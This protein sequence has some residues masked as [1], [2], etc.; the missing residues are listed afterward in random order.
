MMARGA[1]HALV[2]AWLRHERGRSALTILG[3][4]LGVAVL[5]AIDL[6]IGSSVA[7]FKQTL[8]EVAGRATLTIRS[9][10]AGLPGELAGEVADHPGVI[11]TAPLIQTTATLPAQDG[12]TTQ[13]ML[14]L[15]VD[16]LFSGQ[17]A[18]PAVREFEFQLQPERALES[19]LIDP[20]VIMIPNQLAKRLGKAAGDSFRLNVGGFEHTMT[21]GAIIDAGELADAM[22]GAVGVMDIAMV[23]RLLEANGRIDRIDLVTDPEVSVDTVAE[24]LRRKLGSSYLVERPAARGEQVDAMMAA[25]R[26]NLRALG[27]ISILVGAFLIFNTMNVAVVRRTEVIGT[28]RAMGLQRGVIRRV[29]LLEGAAMGIIGS[30]LGIGLG[31]LMARSLLGIVSRA[32]SI[33]Y[34]QVYRESLVL[35]ETTLIVAMVL[36]VGGAVGAAWGPANLAASIPPANTMR[37][38]GVQPR[39]GGNPW[40]TLAVA[41]GLILGAAGLIRFY[42]TSFSALPW[43]SELIEDSPQPW[44][45]YLASFLVVMAFVL[46]SRPFFRLLLAVLRRPVA[47]TFG[48]E[49]LLAVAG[50]RAALNRAGVAISGLLIAMG[51][52]VSVGVMVDSFRE[53]VQVWMGQALRAD[54]YLSA[55]A[56]GGGDRPG[57]MPEAIADAVE[58]LPGVAGVDPFRLREVTIHNRPSFL[59]AGRFDI[60]RYDENLRILDGR[61]ANEVVREALRDGGVIVS[62]AF[63]RKQG[64]GRGDRVPIPTPG[65]RVELPIVGVFYDYSTELGYVI[66]D[67]SL[68]REFYDD[69]MINTLAV[70]LDSGADAEAIREEVRG[71]AN[72]LP[73]M[74]MVQLRANEELRGFAL[75]AFNRTFQ[76]TWVMELIAILIA[77][78]G[79][80]NTL[81]SQI[82]DRR[83]EILTLRTL[84]IS[85]GRV[86]K[87]V[88]I[89]SGLVGL[90]GV[91]LG[92][93]AGLALSWILAKIIMLES[94]GW[95]IQF[96][97]PW[98]LVLELA[99][100]VLASTFLAGILPAREAGRM[101]RFSGYQG[102]H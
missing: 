88:I 77:V 97:I 73:G 2:G 75:N 98:L 70:Y 38:G 99:G 12:S 19:F 13:G 62:E 10:G 102:M 6:A 22:D 93:G 33:N 66:M 92:I 11:S 63:Y 54:L 45:G 69:P 90:T 50:S 76:V 68:Y 8:E 49:G 47:R 9:E 71:L 85:K 80:A 24:S 89:E 78:L 28:L 32:V 1:F 65:G 58:R 101:G 16:L 67:R 26:F 5:V 31:L 53:T 95:T 64:L 59:G 44:L 79:V 4:A 46:L 84:G 35:T 61:P 25:F 42:Q 37:R 23:D 43:V 41:F 91:L 56:G 27:L 3:V 82:L 15:G 100:V 72:T 94:F 14:L 83:D 52:T 51:M 36:G 48:A 21:I 74:P 96:R 87:V 55:Q 40:K 60:V 39:P 29:F 57:L 17:L 86:A 18:G 81:L 7:G 34:F 30:A 20:R